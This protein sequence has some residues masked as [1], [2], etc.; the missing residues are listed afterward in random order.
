MVQE[1]YM[2]VFVTG[3]TGF[4]GGALIRKLVQRGDEVYALVRSKQ[5]AQALEIIGVPGVG[6]VTDRESMR[7]GMAGS[8][9]V[10]HVAGSYKIGEMDS[11]AEKINVDGTQNV[12]SLAHELGVPKII[13]TSTVA[14][15]GDTH[16]QLVDETYQMPPEQDFLTDYDRTK[17]LAHYAVAALIQKGAPIVIVQ[18]GIVIGPGDQSLV[19]EL[20][21]RYYRGKFPFPFLTGPEFTVTY[22]YLDDIVDGHLL[23]AERGKPGESYVITGPALSLAQTVNLWS[24][25]TGK[26]LPVLSIPARFLTPFAPLMGVIQRI[27]PLP[28]VLSRDTLAMLNVTYTARADKARKELGW[29][30]RPV[31]VAFQ[32]TFEWI[33]GQPEPQ[34]D[35]VQR[36]RWIAGLAAGAA[37]GIALVWFLRRGRWRQR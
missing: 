26:P 20:M 16:G 1:G 24:Q 17:W 18:P 7:A 36:R 8:D 28:S 21:T 15:F 13:Y 5:S 3:G 25:I 12:L 34:P 6:D 27:V 32:Q 31:Q 30:P 9:I 10:F 33:A 35:P 2:K 23:A 11:Q 14:V 4:I 29:E 19:G 37:L 22:A